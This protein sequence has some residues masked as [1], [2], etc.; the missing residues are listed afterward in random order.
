MIPMPSVMSPQR[1]LLMSATALM[2]VVVCASGTVTTISIGGKAMSVIPEATLVR[3]VV[4][5]QGKPPRKL[6]VQVP[7]FAIDT[8]P[9]TNAEFR[10]FVRDT[11]YRTEA[12]KFGWSFVLAP[13]VEKGADHPDNK[14]IPGAEHWMAVR[15][16][17]WRQPFGKGSGIT[18]R[19]E[20]PVVQVSYNDAKAFCAWAGKRLPTEAE[21]ELAVRG[22][23]EDATYSWGARYQ[24]NRMN[25][26]QG[27]F[28]KTN[29][30]QDGYHGA[31]PVDAFG[32][33]NDYGLYNMLG[34]TWEW[35]AD[36]YVPLDGSPPP[37]EPQFTLRGGSYLDS[38]DGKYNHKVDVTTRMGNTPDSA[39]DNI[40]F[41]CAAVV[42]SDSEK[43]T[44]SHTND[45]L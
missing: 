9:T 4:T 37:Q 23:L 45:E 6:P 20:Y 16:A 39:S 10:A 41:R 27:D 14:P 28:P 25:I 21:W 7:S 42:D 34:N 32:P 29:T 17:F 5:Q 8:Q 15:R 30:L 31:A 33:Q 18:T 24:K 44:K 43:R 40:G 13:F 38:I 22:G 2:M 36:E 1:Q 3:S 11:K 19:S 12:E 35:V 26:W